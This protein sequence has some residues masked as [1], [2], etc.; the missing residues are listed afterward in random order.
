MS[1]GWAL[2]GYMVV[3][4][5]N[6]VLPRTYEWNAVMERTLGKADVL[7]VTQLD[8]AGRKLMR[9]DNYTR[10]IPTSR[11]SFRYKRNDGYSIYQALQVQFR[12]RSA[13]SLFRRHRSRR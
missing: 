10:R 2:T 12:N 3:V 4:D 13:W 6:H 8:T 11:V 7:T 1:P 9:T 5:P